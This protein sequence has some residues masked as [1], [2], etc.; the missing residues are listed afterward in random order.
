MFATRFATLLSRKV[1]VHPFESI[2]SGRPVTPWI[3]PKAPHQY[4][5]NRAEDAL[6]ST[7]GMEYALLAACVIVSER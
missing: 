2:D 1:T 3:Q 7:F 5:W 6:L 4:D